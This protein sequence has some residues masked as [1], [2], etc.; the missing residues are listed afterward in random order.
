MEFI[1]VGFTPNDLIGRDPYLSGTKLFATS[2][3]GV[4]GGH[5]KHLAEY[6]DGFLV[7]MRRALKGDEDEMNHLIFRS[8]R[9]PAEFGV[10]NY[11]ANTKRIYDDG[12]GVV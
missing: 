1:L 9:K 6:N 8:R 10:V 11:M 12:H 5:E 4:P 7:D 2:W 3:L